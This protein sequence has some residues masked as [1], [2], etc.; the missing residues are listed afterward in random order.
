M[1]ASRQLA[2]MRGKTVNVLEK[3][4]RKR[5]LDFAQRF[6]LAGGRHARG[7]QYFNPSG[8]FPWPTGH[9]SAVQEKDERSRV[10]LKS[11]AEY[12]SLHLNI[13]LIQ[14]QQNGRG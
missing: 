3:R 9:R 14:T 10:W 12:S 4:R 11:T 13:E 2:K 5:V 8:K 6:E 1:A 7:S